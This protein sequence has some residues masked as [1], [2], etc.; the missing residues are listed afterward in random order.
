M[1]QTWP[2]SWFG[3]ALPGVLPL[4]L[5]STALGPWP[6]AEVAAV[7]TP[8]TFRRQSWKSAAIIVEFVMKKIEEKCLAT[9]VP[10][11]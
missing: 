5:L 3:T 2:T 6:R 11:F 10:S 9:Y 7:A 1:S 8:T 4:V